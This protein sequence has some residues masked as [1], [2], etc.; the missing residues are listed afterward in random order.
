MLK[1]GLCSITF[2]DLS[3]DQIIALT[4]KA[5][6]DGI[7]WGGDIHVPSGSVERA[8]EVANLTKQ[9]GLSIVSY[10]SY[11]RVGCENET[12]FEQILET[13]IHLNAPAI[14][15]WA[16]NRSS[17]DADKTYWQTVISDSRKIGSLAEKEGIAI[18]YEYHDDTLTDTKASAY[19]L[20]KAVNHPNIGVYWQP[21]IDQDVETRIES[22]K[23][24]G[25]WLTHVHVFQWSTKDRFP[26]SEGK[27]EW[28]RYLRNLENSRDDRYMMLEFVKDDDP[29]QMLEDADVLKRLISS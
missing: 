23:E 3:V 2:R 27:Q 15:V 5:G 24:I 29:K 22:I 26:L 7:E 28:I 6:L 14:R 25:P 1:T 18:N 11:Y 8:S 10:G 9:A 4:V 19:K 12:S 21:A 16:G 17:E 20:M 13:A